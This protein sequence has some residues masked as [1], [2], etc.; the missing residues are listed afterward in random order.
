[1][2][3]PHRRRNRPPHRAFPD[4][5]DVVQDVVQ[6]PVRLGPSARPV[7]RVQ[8]VGFLRGLC[9]VHQA[10]SFRGALSPPSATA[11]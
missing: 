1:M 7:L 4:L 9:K 10:V 11:G 8:V 6:H 2:A 5:L 3:C